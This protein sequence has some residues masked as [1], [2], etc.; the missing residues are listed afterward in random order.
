MRVG[1]DVAR[2]A[3]SVAASRGV[4]PIL[5]DIGRGV[6]PFASGSFDMVC[7]FEVLEHLT[8]E[9]RQTVTSE[10][11]RVARRWILIS[12][13]DNQDLKADCARC[14]DCDREYHVFGHIASFTPAALQS[15]FPEFRSA[16]VNRI[17]YGRRYL[18]WENVFRHRWAQ[19]Y[20]AP[21]QPCPACGSK[22]GVPRRRGFFGNLAHVTARLR[23]A[24]V[25]TPR[26]LLIR[27]D[28]V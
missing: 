3:L 5:Y 6:L 20:E 19:D 21:W 22:R 10:M 11:R 23:E 25:P 26:W 18:W 1:M 24:V 4:Q 13:P 12:V 17:G 2:A 8:D 27:F 16:I 9:Q 28:R 15:L 14:A 7:A